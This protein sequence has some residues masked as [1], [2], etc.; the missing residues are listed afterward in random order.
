MSGYTAFRL[1]YWLALLGVLGFLLATYF[2]F[3]KILP[4][5]HPIKK[6]LAEQNKKGFFLL[7]KKLSVLLLFSSLIVVVVLYG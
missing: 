4:I 6:F 1:I 5:E 7:A 2:G 3:K